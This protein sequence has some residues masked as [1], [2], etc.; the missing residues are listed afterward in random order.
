[1]AQREQILVVDDEESVLESTAEL[2]EHR[3]Y[4]CDRAPDGFLAAELLGQK[5]Y[6]L[7]IS[8]IRMPGNFELELVQRAH[9]VA[10]GMPVVLLT[11]HP[12]LDTAIHSIRLPVVDYLIKPLDIDVLEPKIRDCVHRARI[13]RQVHST[14]EQVA[15]WTRELEAAESVLHQTGETSLAGPVDAFLTTHLKNVAGTLNHFSQFSAAM[16]AGLSDGEKHELVATAQLDTARDALLDAIR[17]L[18]ETRSLF[19]SKQLA[20]LRRR[21]QGILDNWFPDSGN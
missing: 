14:R 19:K 1:M 13:I 7:L 12:S 8:D 17:V 9:E 11:G 20:R 15:R 3:G 21:L 18:E 16:A 4:Q 2:L 5:Q 6:D 10:R